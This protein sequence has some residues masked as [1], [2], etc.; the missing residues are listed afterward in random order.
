MYFSK[1]AAAATV[2]VC[3]A[4]L[5]A[6]GDDP[7]QLNPVVVTPTLSTQTVD[8]SL[9][10]VT[11][12]DRETLDRQQPRELGD[13]LRGQPGLD[14]QTNGSFGK[15]TS[16]YT[17]GTGSESTMLLIDGVRIRSATTGGVPW[18]FIPPQLLD[19]VEVVR[20][21]RASIYGA[22]AVGGVVQAF[23]PDGRDGDQY[24]IQGG[25]GSFDSS[26]IGAGFA[27][28][29]DGT[30][31][32]V[33]TNRFHT[34]GAPVREDGDDRGFVNN[35]NVG[36]LTHQFDNGTEVGVL[37]FRAEGNTEFDGGDTD[38]LN[39]A[40]GAHTLIPIGAAWTTRLQISQARDEQ[41][42]FEGSGISVFDTETRTARMENTAIH[43]NNE[44]V[45]GAEFQ[46]DEV[47]GTTDYDETRRDNRAAFGQYLIGGDNSEIQL[48]V[49]LDDNE[50]FGDRVTGGAAFGQALDANHRL[51]LSYGTAFRAPTFNDLYFPF[52]DYGDGF[53]FE[54]NDN[55][56]PERSQTAEIGITGQY[57][58]LRWDLA[59]YQSHVDDLIQNAFGNDGVMRPENVD[60]ARIQGLEGSLQ[61]R[62]SAWDV[63][64]SATLTDPRDRDSGERLER[65]A[66][67]T[68]RLDLDRS[69]G[70]A[71]VGASGIF[72]GDRYQGDDRLPGFGL[73]NLRAGWEFARNWSARLTIDNVFDT[74]Y[75][76]A[77]NSTSDFD[78]K[79]AGRTA[80]LSVRYGNR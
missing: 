33:S 79:N 40:I 6:S 37:G 49:R 26:E 64:A 69:I 50:A 21:P 3:L 43:G 36:R 17:R 52:T 30:S 76:T 34:R 73:M 56:S 16:V 59:A 25:Y 38:F 41:E 55:L 10:S 11:V 8:E 70:T 2:A 20:G 1:P 78:Y 74:D 77:R 23:T 80:F 12:I 67:R 14:V 31:Y 28:A 5:S 47:A 7:I 24:W 29:A 68:A 27:G 4:P 9:S 46:R 60:R 15:A 39:Q 48:S 45:F 62:I 54:G 58:H 65:R 32:S 19:N 42:N 75:V 35:A 72:Q 57:Q 13:I 63:Q 51:R 22:D 44:V 61:T 71:S 53:I 18:Q 66:T